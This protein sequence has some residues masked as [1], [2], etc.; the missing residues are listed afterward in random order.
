MF[1]PEIIGDESMGVHQL[2][3]N[4]ISKV[5][6]DLRSCLFS[7]ILLSGGTTLLKGFGDRLLLELKKQVP[8]ESKVKIYAPPERKYSTWIGGSI[9]ASLSTFK[10]MWITSEEYFED[11]QCIH[12]KTF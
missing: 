8:K 9:L 4:S 2:I 6:M 12:R 3:S 10:K 7:N 11:P 5:D 1:H